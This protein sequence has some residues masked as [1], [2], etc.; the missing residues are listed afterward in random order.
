MKPKLL[1]IRP[2]YQ[3]LTQNVSKQNLKSKLLKMKHENPN[4]TQN[5]RHF[6]R[7]TNNK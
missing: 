7:L 2:E 1:K 5:V 4:R 3:N 6:T